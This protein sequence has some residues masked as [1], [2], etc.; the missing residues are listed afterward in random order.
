[1][2]KVTRKQIKELLENPENY[3]CHLTESKNVLSIMKDG[4]KANKDGEIF[5]YDDY[6][7]KWMGMVHYVGDSIAFNQVMFDLKD[8]V[9]FFIDK[10]DVTGEVLPDDVGEC[11]SKFQ[12]IIKQK[13]IEPFHFVSRKNEYYS[14]YVEKNKCYNEKI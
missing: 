7:F 1:M 10:R 6:M 13:K 12:H 2:K 5:V 11:T 14:I 3:Y 4:I 9:I 8:Y